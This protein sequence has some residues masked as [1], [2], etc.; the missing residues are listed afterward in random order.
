MTDRNCFH[1]NRLY[2]HK[3]IVQMCI[4]LIVPL[5]NMF[6]LVNYFVGFSDFRRRMA[7]FEKKT[8]IQM[9][10]TTNAGV[11]MDLTVAAASA[12]QDN[13]EHDGSPETERLNSGED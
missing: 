7:D 6:F 9:S 11:Y 1:W 4:V 5:R 3:D 8:Q 12:R 10:S 2:W 13:K